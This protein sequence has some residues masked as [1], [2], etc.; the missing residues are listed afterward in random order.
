MVNR[1][2]SYDAYSWDDIAYNA[3]YYLAVMSAGNDGQNEDN[4]E[5]LGI[6]F[7]KLVANKTAKII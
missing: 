7:D 4:P 5:S 3:P 1:S 6:G 2:Y